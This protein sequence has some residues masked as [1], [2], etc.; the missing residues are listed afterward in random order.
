MPKLVLVIA[1]VLGVMRLDQKVLTWAILRSWQCTFCC[2]KQIRDV[3]LLLAPLF[4][5]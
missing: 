5:Q 4:Y 3:D 1:L 2:L